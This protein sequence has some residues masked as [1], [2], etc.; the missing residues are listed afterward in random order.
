MLLLSAVTA[1]AAT[2]TVATAAASAGALPGSTAHALVAVPAVHRAVAARLERNLGRLATVTAHDVEQFTVGAR[3][4]AH[5]GT[6]AAFAL[7]TAGAAAIAAA[8]RFGESA[9]GVE[10]L[11]IRREDELRPAVRTR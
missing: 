5:T 2:A 4:A 10:L 6:V 3:R 7:D 8:L 9:L 11:V 1:A